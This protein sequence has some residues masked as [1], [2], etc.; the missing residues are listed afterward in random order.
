MWDDAPAN[1]S[2]AL[3]FDT[4]VLGLESSMNFLWVFTKA[5]IE[6]MTRDNLTSAG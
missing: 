5:T 1:G 4:E 2:E 3:T 6:K